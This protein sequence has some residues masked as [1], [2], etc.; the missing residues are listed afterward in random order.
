MVAKRP[1]STWLP[2]G[3]LTDEGHKGAWI[4]SVIAGMLDHKSL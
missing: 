1:L 2:W 4:E 3:G